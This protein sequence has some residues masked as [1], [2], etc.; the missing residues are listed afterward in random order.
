MTGY[1]RRNLTRR[2]AL[3]AAIALLIAAMFMAGWLTPLERRLSDQRT[4]W[5]QFKVTPP[6]DE[7]IHLDIDD[8]A[9]EVIHRWPWPRGIWADVLDELRLAESRTVAFDVLFSEP[10]VA[11][12]KARAVALPGIQGEPAGALPDEPESDDAKFARAVAAHG[13]VLLPSTF[14]FTRHPP[15]YHAAVRLM[16]RNTLSL[17]SWEKFS[18]VAASNQTAGD[19]LP[20]LDRDAYLAA[21]REA[22]FELLTA[23][24]FMY[25]NINQPPSLA[26]MQQLYFPNLDPAVTSGA[27]LRLLQQQ[28][29]KSLAYT[30]IKPWGFWLYQPLDKLPEADDIIP[31]VGELALQASATGFVNVVP[32][33]GGVVRRVPSAVRFRGDS[34]T[35]LG[36]AMAQLHRKNI[37]SVLVYKDDGLCFL[38]DKKGIGRI[39]YDQRGRIVIP[40]TGQVDDWL[41]VIG[42]E[43]HLSVGYVWEAAS[44]AQALNANRRNADLAIYDLYHLALDQAKARQ[45]SEQSFD[46]EDDQARALRIQS[47]LGEAA[48]MGYPE[49]LTQVAADT[50]TREE[51]TILA[52]IATLRVIPEQNQKLATQLAIHRADLQKRLADKA[53]LVGFTASGLGDVITTPLHTRCPGVIAHGAIFNAIMTNSFW[54]Q[55]SWSVSLPVII[56]MGLAGT[57]FAVALAPAYSAS[58]VAIMLCIFML[59][60]G[61]ILFDRWNF[62]LALA[63]PMLAMGASWAVCTFMGLI[64]ERRERT[65][66]T[67]RFQNYVDPTLVN[68]VIENPDKARLEGEART[69]SVVFTD[70]E[71]FTKLSSTIHERVVPVINRYLEQMIPPIHANNGYV[72]KFLGDGIMFF[73]GAPRENAKHAADAVTSIMQM[74]KLMDPFNK[75]LEDDGLPTLRMRVGMTTGRMI[76]GDAG[77]LHRSDYTVM[78]DQ[79]NF[80]ARLESANKATGTSILINDTAAELVQDQYLLRPI[81]RLQVVGR[82]EAVMCFEPICLLTEAGHPRRILVQATHQLIQ[83]YTEKRWQDCLALADEIL[84]SD[85]ESRTLMALYKLNIARQQEHPTDAFDGRIELTSK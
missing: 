77:S 35:Q 39:P 85:P 12:G 65:R 63:G 41:S 75:Q 62:Q 33:S 5:C 10:Q 78:G 71:G 49:A 43:H 70:L 36:I 20:L 13:N 3:G 9:L 80:A 27:V 74:Q 72:N 84:A 11:A 60:N 21:R 48:N 54:S 64:L 1:Q 16:I 17:A 15:E 44:M 23:Q 53:V 82:S 7:L 25:R 30:R 31:P 50:L 4:A 34:Y 37:S 40:W 46:F 57:F 42:K 2:A 47:V 73:F 18:V 8:S 29:D 76:V 51:Q 66:I 61:L 55:A 24:F 69:M 58:A 19:S 68:Y 14:S 38:S 83:A 59:F 81:G 79:V 45:L 6:S 67:R 26:Q 28:Y 32:D 22:L 52:A 56:F